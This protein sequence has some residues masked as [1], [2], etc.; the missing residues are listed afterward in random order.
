MQNQGAV[1]W[2]AISVIVPVK[3][4]SSHLAACLEGILAQTVPVS[5][6]IVIDSGSTDGTQDIARSIS[7]VKLIEIRPE[8]F[9]HGDTRNLG[10]SHATGEFVLFTVGDAKPASD[11]WIEHLLAGLVS[12]DVAAV[13]GAQVVP[14]SKSTNPAEW[15]KPCSQPIIS[16][17]RFGSADAFLSAPAEQKHTACSLD[18][19]TALYRKAALQCIPFR[20]VAYGEDILWAM[21]ALMAG[22][23]I[24][25]NPAARVHHFHL[26]D[27]QT[28]VRRTMTVTSLRYSIF[29]F[30]TPAIDVFRPLAR[31]LARL[32]RESSLSWSE[33]LYWARYN[34]NLH[35]GLRDGLACFHR[36]VE[37]DDENLRKLRDAF[38]GPEPVLLQSVQTEVFK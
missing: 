1:T 8:Q 7:K 30:E 22:C 4:E 5:E 10:V 18:D 33:R 11:V 9:N 37:A 14:E 2:P 12:A 6:I 19:V 29:G 13:C 17:H 32:L 28:T 27:Y 21:D 16:I 23:A 26:V 25:Y 34:F 36:A 31:S 15:F 3:N 38:C 24:A 35:R 20:R